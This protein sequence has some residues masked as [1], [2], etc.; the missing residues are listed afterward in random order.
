L[1][2]IQEFALKHVWKCTNNKLTDMIKK[3]EEMS[4]N[5][6]KMLDEYKTRSMI[7]KTIPDPVQ[8]PVIEESGVEEDVTSTSWFCYLL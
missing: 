1:A 6:R 5:C 4:A 8:E 7:S 2:P 3:S